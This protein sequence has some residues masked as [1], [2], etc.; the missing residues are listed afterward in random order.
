MKMDSEVIEFV[1]LKI[2]TDSAEDIDTEKIFDRFYQR[3]S[4]RTKGGAGLGLYICKEFV[5]RM[6]GTISASQD[7]DIFEICLVL[8][9]L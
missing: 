2:Q 7:N 1:K 3:D 4:S 6:N 8:E 5:E 9:K